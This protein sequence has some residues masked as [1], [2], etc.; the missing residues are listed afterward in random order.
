[1]FGRKKKTEA[2]EASKPP[3]AGS[4]VPP[5]AGIPY[6]EIPPESLPSTQPSF[7][8]ALPTSGSPPLFVKL[9]KYTD[10]QTHL[11]EL[12]SHASNMRKTLDKLTESH[13]KL[14][15]SLSMSYNMLDKIN[16][17]LGFL[18]S[19]FSGKVMRT[20]EQA[21]LSKP[22]SPPAPGEAP[23]DKE[24]ESYIKGITNQ[25]EKIKGELEKAK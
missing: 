10:I 7:E 6:Q 20:H 1:M 14:H 13:K 2:K 22:L 3:A 16:Q 19:K 24:M 5:S 9:D 15:M 23:P 18:E 17:T 25:M 12:R 11:Q 4:A 21:P 8:T